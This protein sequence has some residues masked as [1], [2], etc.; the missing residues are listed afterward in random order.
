MYSILAIYASCNIGIYKGMSI[1]RTYTRIYRCFFAGF[2]TD[3]FI[4]M[5]MHT[6]L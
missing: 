1:L 6:V 4:D 2:V 3:I 5:S